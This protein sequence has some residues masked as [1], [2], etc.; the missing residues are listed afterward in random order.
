MSDPWRVLRQ[1]TTR[2]HGGEACGAGHSR[3]IA[4]AEYRAF[5]AAAAGAEVS[6]WEHL[7]AQ[8]FLGS[9][10][11]LRNIEVR[12]KA[13]EW[14]HEHPKPQRAFRTATLQTIRAALQAGKQGE[15][16]PPAGSIDRLAFAWIAAQ[17]TDATRADIG[18]ALAITGQAAG[19][20]IRRAEANL[21]RD[22]DGNLR[23]V[24]ATI[25]GALCTAN[26]E[27]F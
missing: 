22:R 14:S 5:V 17:S 12:L 26:D 11:F 7:V 2:R 6:P 18:R 13:R 24:V 4:T 16:P 25:R 15:W 8:A 9:E 27:P 20:L 3:R 21:R 23:R 10:D 19:K 1:L